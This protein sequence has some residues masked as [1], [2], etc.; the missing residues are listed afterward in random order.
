MKLMPRPRG[1]PPADATGC[2]VWTVTPSG[3][4]TTG[5]D[6]NPKNYTKLLHI[7]ETGD[8]LAEGG[9]YYLSFSIT[10]AR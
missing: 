1:A 8:I 2:K 10:F 9:D 6:P 3:T 5:T 4:T 7:N